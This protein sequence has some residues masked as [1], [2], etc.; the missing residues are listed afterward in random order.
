M[1]IKEMQEQSGLS[2]FNILYY[3][4]E[5]LVV[6]ERRKDGYRDY[7]EKDLEELK[8]IRLFRELE[9]PIEKIKEL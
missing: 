4:K 1:N 8:R 3:E 6:P 2:R 9:V 7:S 5:G